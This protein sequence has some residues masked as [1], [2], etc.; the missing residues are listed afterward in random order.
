MGDIIWDNSNKLFRSTIKQNSFFRVVFFTLTMALLFVCCESLVGCGETEEESKKVETFTNREKLAEFLG[1]DFTDMTMIYVQCSNLK[2]GG[3]SFVFF[4]NGSNDSFHSNKSNSFYVFNSEELEYE[5]TP[6]HR[7][8]LKSWGI[9]ANDIQAHGLSFKDYELEGGGEMPI[10]RWW[11]LLDNSDNAYKGNI[12]LRG[13][14]PYA[15]EV[16]VEK[17]ISGQSE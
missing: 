8:N 17:I 15:I 2:N 4:L 13:W 14:V 7:E 6:N 16:D 9:D 5:L 1:V 12:H 3:T 11:Y 10:E